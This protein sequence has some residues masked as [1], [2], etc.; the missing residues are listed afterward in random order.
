M[1]FRALNWHH[2]LPVCIQS[3]SEDLESKHETIYYG[4]SQGDVC[5]LTELFHES[6]LSSWDEAELLQCPTFP[7]SPDLPVAPRTQL[8]SHV[9]RFTLS[10]SLMISFLPL[11]CV[12]PLTTFSTAQHIKL[13]IWFTW[14]KNALFP[15]LF[16]SWISFPTWSTG[17]T[18]KY[19]AGLSIGLRGSGG[20]LGSGMGTRD[21]FWHSSLN[22]ISR[23][24][25]LHQFMPS[26]RSRNKGQGKR[27]LAS[28]L[29]LD[30][31]N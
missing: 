7:W 16:L 24:L 31:L 28:S 3:C 15:C 9:F 1:L 20:A 10:S 19:S 26:G 2:H 5:L 12:L 22:Q 29:V 30:W 21:K 13:G 4:V 14:Q 25:S 8:N 23:C 17:W 11:S 6:P 18:Q 27:S